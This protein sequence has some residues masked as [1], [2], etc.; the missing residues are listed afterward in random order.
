MDKQ[1][2]TYV[3][4][5]IKQICFI[6]N[7][8]FINLLNWTRKV[9]YM[10]VLR[11]CSVLHVILFAQKLMEVTYLPKFISFVFNGLS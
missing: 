3:C 9:I 4:G 8:L 7:L 5:I 11:F 10:Y 2:S 1:T 6:G